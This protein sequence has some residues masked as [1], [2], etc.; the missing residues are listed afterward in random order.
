MVSLIINDFDNQNKGFFYNLKDTTIFE[1]FY[2]T[3]INTFP[4][5]VYSTITISAPNITAAVPSNLGFRD[6]FVQGL[7]TIVVTELGDKTFFLAGEI[8]TFLKT[9]LE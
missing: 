3:T 8:K 4:D 1:D 7:T 9:I 6:S 2:P 5:D